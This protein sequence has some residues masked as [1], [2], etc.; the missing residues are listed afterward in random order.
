[1]SA[2]LLQQL[3]LDPKLNKLRYRAALVLY[4]AIVAIGAIPGARQEIGQVASGIVLHTLAYGCVSVLLYTGSS[5]SGAWR[6]GKTVLTIA[7]MG[8]LDETVQGFLPYRTGA[9]ADFLIDCN[10]AVIASGLLW[11]FLPPPAPTR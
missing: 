3:V 1:M 5:G 2:S 6:A 11:A 8:A 10:A 4:L 7:L 9:L